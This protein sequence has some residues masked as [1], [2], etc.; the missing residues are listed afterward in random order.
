MWTANEVCELKSQDLVLILKLLCLSRLGV[1][2]LVGQEFR[3]DEKGWLDTAQSL[4]KQ[5]EA[6]DA[7]DKADRKLEHMYSVRGLSDELGFSKSEVANSLK[8]SMSV[9]L[10][11]LDRRTKRPRVNIKAVFNILQHS[12]RYVFP[13][14]PAEIVRG[15]PTTFAAP[16]LKGKLLSAGEL[17]M[18]WADPMGNEMGQSIAPLYKSVP[19]A[20]RRDK[21]LYAYLALID[22]IRIGNARESGLATKLLKEKFFDE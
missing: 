10:I 22:A 15:I 4:D 3:S 16:I 21:E 7:Y 17:K 14:K 12:I 20:V 2:S 5:F 11:L 9:G 6:I 13:V 19:H 1:H 8:R 18:V